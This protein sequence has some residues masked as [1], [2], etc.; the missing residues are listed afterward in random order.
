MAGAMYS[1]YQLYG[2]AD[3]APFRNKPFLYFKE[4]GLRVTSK[5]YHMVFM[6]NI[7][8]DLTVFDIKDDY[9]T[10]FFPKKI[11]A[12]DVILINRNC[13]LYAYFCDGD[14]FLLIEGFIPNSSSNAVIEYN[15][16]DYVISGYG[17]KWY[18]TES[19]NI[20]G[21]NYYLMEHQELGKSTFW[22]I[23]DEMGEVVIDKVS[24]GF[25]G[26]IIECIKNCMGNASGG[27]TKLE[28]W[29]KAYENGEYLR[30][31]EINE[32]ANYNMIDGRINNI[33]RPSV[34]K[35]LNRK[36]QEVSARYGNSNGA[37]RDGIVKK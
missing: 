37:V 1:V 26:D 13:V 2:R 21:K 33:K 11:E 6:K 25:R 14:D 12:S 10:L 30:T 17:G 7:E 4:Q 16:K 15:T 23:L 32:E 19:L 24:D 36:K 8:A 18:S 27:N 34:L 28:N 31:A 29:Q 20:N 35:R 3:L 22:I 5:I 9:N